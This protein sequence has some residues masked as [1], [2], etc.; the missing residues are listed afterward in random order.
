MSFVSY[1]PVFLDLG[2]KSVLIVGGGFVAMEKLETLLPT[3][4]RITVISPTAT[5]E[6]LNWNSEGRLTYWAREF[7]DQ[8]AEP[9]FMVIAA[10]NVPEVNARVFHVGE[11]LHR[12]SNSVD[13][14]VNCNFIMSAI[15]RQG[16][17]QVAV[18]SAGCSPALA[19]RLR[20][21]IA[22]DLLTHEMG[23]L[24]EFLGGWRPR[25]KELLSGYK[26]K[27]AFWEGVIDSH[28]P[29]VLANEG[30]ARADVEMERHL[31]S[32]LLGMPIGV[33]RVILIG[34]GPGDP[35]LITVKGMKALESAD[36][37]LYD[38]LTNPSLLK[39]SKVNAL[40]IDVGKKAGECGSPRQEWIHALM[41]EHAKR[42]KV[43]A[44]LKGGDPFVFGRGGEEVAALR[45]A[46]IPYE[47]IPGVSASIAA[48]EAAEIPVTHRGVA[49]GFAVFTAQGASQD[50]ETVP[51]E[52]IRHVPT[53][54]LL[55]GVEKLPDIL[56]RL[57]AEGRSEDLPVAVISHA[58]LPTQEIA[59]GT[60]A[61]I[62]KIAKGASSPATI[63]VGEVVKM[64]KNFP[65]DFVESLNLRLHD[66]VV[67]S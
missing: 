45:D 48:A 12:L 67:N 53:L 10:T 47:I 41:I 19:Q 7:R 21:K 3:G 15:T 22:D 24:A 5:P 23:I 49:T 43:V 30:R 63:V 9:F 2:G 36:V 4:A 28:I 55:M 33:G 32:H 38:R 46:N 62:E 37:V 58:T 56:A 18:S 29:E 54:V 31:Q 16:P 6:I 27:Q 57:R 52:A 59:L 17:M 34:A 25:I 39:H 64:A 65:N 60:I 61:T 13:D 35:D 40:L 50:I 8:D 11:S 14:P 26:V 1:H 42:G 20:K 44:R 51:W 66:V